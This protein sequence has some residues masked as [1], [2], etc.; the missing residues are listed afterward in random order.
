VALAAVAAPGYVYTMNL[1]ALVILAALLADYVLNRIADVLN[2][3]AVR[4][5]VP[6]EFR[7]VYDAEAYRTSQ[8]Y[9][10]VT[11]RFGYVETTAALGL[12]LVFW[13]AGGFNGLDRLLRGWQLGSIWTGLIYIGLL[14]LLRTLF[15]LPFSAYATFVIERRF[16]FNRTSVTTFIMDLLKGLVLAL[17]LGGPLL[18]G[19]LAFLDFAG[20]YAWLYCW[21]ATTVFALVVQFVA[22][23]WIMPLFNRFTPLPEGE[24]RSAILA[25]TAEAAFPVG[26]LFVI[27]GSRRSTHSNAFVAGFGRYRR[28]ALYDTLIARHTVAEL[29]GIVAHEVGHWK[30]RHIVTGLVLGIAH[31]GLVFFLLSVFL[32]APGL[33]VAFGME[34]PSAYAALLFFS[35]LYTPIERVLSVLLHWLSRRNEF[36]ADGYAVTSTGNPGTLA[37]ALKK[38]SVH[39]LSNLT[40]HPLTVWL[41]YSHPPVLERLRALA[42]HSE[43]AN[44]HRMTVY[45]APSI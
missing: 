23:I 43:P 1:Y 40:P 5:E 37:E 31:T 34:R 44:D 8:E 38:L 39:N 41:H 12:L 3:R 33:F 24:L 15:A 18:A 7:G 28:I 6:A 4:T 13:F 35:L 22:P 25:Y 16:G 29:V 32:Q 11:T 17:L 36:A 21:G 20:P 14:A 45:S 42:D 9:L 26:S 27:D 30:K 2:L 19:V 10:R